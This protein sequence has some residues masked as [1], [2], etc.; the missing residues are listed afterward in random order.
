MTGDF[1]QCHLSPGVGSGVLFIRVLYTFYNKGLTDKSEILFE[2]VKWGGSKQLDPGFLG[3]LTS[4][5]SV[6][7]K[8][9][10]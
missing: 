3:Y 10:L 5:V 6:S 2:A 4:C 1:P 7:L 9:F 8:Q